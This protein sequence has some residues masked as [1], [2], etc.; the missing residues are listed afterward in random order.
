MTTATASS[1]NTSGRKMADQHADER[2]R[3]ES[4]GPHPGIEAGYFA[5]DKAGFL[6]WTRRGRDRLLP[7]NR[8]AVERPVAPPKPA[9]VLV[10][11]IAP[12]PAAKGPDQLKLF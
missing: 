3:L 7:V 2:P 5:H 11:E 9:N 12:R 10:D 8:E 4:M 1:A 6:G